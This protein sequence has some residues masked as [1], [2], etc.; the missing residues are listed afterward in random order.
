MNE[1]YFNLLKEFGIEV[2]CSFTPGISWKNTPGETIM[3][4]DYSHVHKSYH[5]VHDILELPMT[6]RRVRFSKSGS[7]KSRIGTLLFGKNV[8]LRP[9]T[10]TV[11]EMIDL[12]KM[13]Q[14]ERDEDYLELMLHS[15]ELMPNGSPYFKD[16]DSI[17]KLYQVLE[18]L[19]SYVSSVGYEGITMVDYCRTVKPKN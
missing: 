16:K 14:S 6:I 3:G 5:N 9:A 13:V 15:S 1:S 11:K 2:D 12:C 19:F 10:S 7:I 4:T 8:W 18:E 17:D